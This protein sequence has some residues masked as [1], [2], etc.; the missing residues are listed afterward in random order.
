ME[1]KKTTDVPLTSEELYSH[2]PTNTTVR[3]IDI[4]TDLEIDDLEPI[5]EATVDEEDTSFIL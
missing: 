2:S 1:D 4:I 3:K 5:S